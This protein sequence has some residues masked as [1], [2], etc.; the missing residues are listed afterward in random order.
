MINT[1]PIVFFLDFDGVINKHEF[2][3]NVKAPETLEECTEETKHFDAQSL[4]YLD[5]MLRAFEKTR[6]VQIVVSSSWRTGFTIEELR[7]MCARHNMSKYF[8]D[9]TLDT[10]AFPKDQIKDFCS[11][12]SHQTTSC[13]AAEIQEW[14]SRNP[15]VNV[16]VLDDVGG[17]SHLSK[18]FKEKFIKVSP[19]RMITKGI[20]NYVI[21]ELYGEL[22]DPAIKQKIEAKQKARAEVILNLPKEMPKV[23]QFYPYVK[24]AD[25]EAVNTRLIEDITELWTCFLKQQRMQSNP[26]LDLKSESEAW[27]ESSHGLSDLQLEAFKS[28]Y[29]SFLLSILQKDS[30]Q[31][32]EL[33]TRIY[34]A[35]L[36]NAGIFDAKVSQ[37]KFEG[38]NLKTFLKLDKDGVEVN[39]AIDGFE[40]REN[41]SDFDYAS[42]QC[43]IC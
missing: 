30:Y 21:T 37:S 34:H 5:K 17:I 16:V 39:F 35:A 7:T 41:D 6:K 33:G 38:N 28:Y 1:N 9:K 32:Y 40:D 24:G 10:E 19:E 8:H 12:P 36:G 22:V 43:Q 29:R 27:D 23:M 2:E 31:E 18:N 25:A 26:M 20:K 4:K 14:L 42:C 11:Q 15:E 3:A 13:R